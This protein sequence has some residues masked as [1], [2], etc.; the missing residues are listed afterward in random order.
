MTVHQLQGIQYGKG[1]TN[2]Q[3]SRIS[4]LYTDECKTLGGN[5]RRYTFG[6]RF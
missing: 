1:Q 2:C 4:Q 6:K 3:I 5:K